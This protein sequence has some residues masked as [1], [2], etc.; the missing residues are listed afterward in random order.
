MAKQ[1]ISM[2][3][4][5]SEDDKARAEQLKAEGN[6][7]H[8]QGKHVEARSNYSEAIKL[9]GGNAILYANRA[10]SYIASKQ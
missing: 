2:A 8:A 7:L 3:S 5:S 4:D 1:T 6:A 9:D 10:A